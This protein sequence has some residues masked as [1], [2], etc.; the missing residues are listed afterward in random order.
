MQ[1]AMS[2]DDA[3]KILDWIRTDV[4]SEFT[5]Y[6]EL[7]AENNV[8]DLLGQSDIDLYRA[9]GR[10]HQ[11]RRIYQFFELAQKIVDGEIEEGERFLEPNFDIRVAPD[12]GKTPVDD[13]AMEG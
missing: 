5:R 11:I 4:G 8:S 1:L 12:Y 3:R 13:G 9:Q 10:Q 6:L 7:Q 2:K